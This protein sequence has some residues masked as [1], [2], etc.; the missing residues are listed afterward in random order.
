MSL[1]EIFD[2]FNNRMEKIG[3]AS[4]SE[5][6]LLG[7][8]HQTFHCWVYRETDGQGPSL[9]FQLRD[10]KKDTYPSLLDISCAG[11]LIAG[12]R[13]EDGIRELKEE[14]GLD[15]SFKALHP[16]GV[17][18]DDNTITETLIDREFC[19]VFLYKCVKDVSEY[20]FQV[21]EVSGLYFINM[22]KFQQ[23]IQGDIE[24]VVAEGITRNENTGERYEENREVNLRDFV[25]HQKGYYDLILH[26]IRDRE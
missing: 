4:R 5:A 18:V 20:E 23:L 26:E 3:T 19:H 6:H 11:H 13:I 12:E 7:L 22:D 24:S 25:P 15:I 16:C 17:F 1:Y 14:L 21:S 10:A 2:I 9:L 8:W